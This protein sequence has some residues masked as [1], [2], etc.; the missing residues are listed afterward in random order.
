MIITIASGKGGTGKT[1]VAVNLAA[2]LSR[3]E[4]ITVPVRLLDCDVE[5]PD[6]HLFVRPRFSRTE[7]VEVLKPVWHEHLCT[8]CGECARA[9]LHNAIAVVKSKVLIFPELCH[10]CGVCTFVCP[11]GA[12]TERPSPIGKVE[13]E[14][15][16][17]DFAFAHG[18]LN[19]GEA[20]APKVVEEVKKH[21]EPDGITI[22]DASPG[23]ACP[24]VG[25]V[26]GADVAVLVTEPTPFGLND[27]QL[28]VAL[29]LKMGVPTAIVINRS[30][31]TDTL[32]QQYA[33]R[34]GVP[35]I[36]RIPFKRQ[37]AETY[38]RGD[39]L[40]DRHPELRGLLLEIY[41]RACEVASAS[42]PPVPR[43][44]TVEP[45]TDRSVDNA[46]AQSS[47]YREVTVIS[48]KGGT[49]KTT[50]VASLAAMLDGQ[51]LADY[52]VDA[53]DLHL[54][55]KPEIREAEDFV[56]GQKASIVQD[57]CTA[58][59]LCAELCHFNAIEPA[60]F[61]EEG[62]PA[63]YRIDE[64]ACE[65]CGLC[66]HVCP[67]G[68]VE[69]APAVTGQAFV[70]ETKQGPLSHAR[71]G[72]A[73]ENSGKL[74]THV[75]NRASD[76]V[77]GQ[78]ADKI[79]GDGSPGTGC[80]VIA[81]ISGVDLALIVTEPTVSG[82]HDLERVLELTR[83]FGVRSL[84]CINKCDLNAE[85][86]DR[87]RAIARRT[88]SPLIAEIPFDQQ[89]NQALM[90]GQILVN[91]GTGPAATAVRRLAGVLQQEPAQ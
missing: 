51:V 21:A 52:D 74:V 8:G 47:P 89:V 15:D 65:G 85:Q 90:D 91:Y 53:A 66:G 23:T 25:A 42:L 30:D 80:P 68:A 88:D 11:E 59:G 78:E 79:L 12:M 76:L 27:L 64:L 5:E 86:A 63:S 24:V 37:Y 55:L 72:I 34:T 77:V 57:I 71:L 58:C 48:G 83:H 32:I 2:A 87:I 69:I 54:L 38:S 70:S 35:V 81:S 13:L 17:S 9:C 10:A 16:R 43:Q 28:A 39:L 46:T 75:R 4:E 33:D 40:L 7:P 62:E 20:L 56:G 61:D 29:S 6:A 36:G 1:T 19:V 49:G 26:K 73:E 60:E 41:R 82:V 45:V 84:I 14:E 22:I 50:I 3:S 44:Q 18:V 67:V 31:G